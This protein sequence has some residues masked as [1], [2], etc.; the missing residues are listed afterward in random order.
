MQLETKKHFSGVTQKH[1]TR[2]IFLCFLLNSIIYVC[3]QFLFSIPTKH[4]FFKFFLKKSTIF[5]L[6][7]FSPHVN[8]F[9]LV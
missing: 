2:E 7:K 5:S 4:N 6:K 8:F 9:F 3:M 1:Y